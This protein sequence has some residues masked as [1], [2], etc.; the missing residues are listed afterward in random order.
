MSGID[1][2]IITALQEE[3]DAARDAA[4]AAGR[5][6]VGIAAWEDRGAGTPTPYL[7]GGRSFNTCRLCRIAYREPI[8]GFRGVC[9][10]A[11]E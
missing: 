5:V 2:L 8:C 11:S 6:G 3:H 4:L 7:L 1:V 10:Y 9:R